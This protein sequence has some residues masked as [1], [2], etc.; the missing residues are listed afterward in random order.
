MHQALYHPQYGYYS[1]GHAKLGR[2]GDYYTNVSVGPMFGRL[3]AFQFTEIWEQL[4]R[5]PK[6]EIVEQGAHDG[7]FAHDVLRE[8]A[9][10][11]PECSETI[12]YHIIE[13]FPPLRE[14]QENR[15]S[16]FGDRLEWSLAL[17]EVEPFVGV[18]FSNELLD[19]MPVH[20]VRRS[21]KDGDSQWT[22]KL[23]NWQDERFGF[24]EAPFSDQRIGQQLGVLADVPDEVEVEINLVAFDWITGLS[25]KLRDGHVIAIDYGYVTADLLALRQRAGTLQCRAQHRL[26]DSPFEVIGH[27]DITAHVNWSAIASHAENH[28]FIL[29][30]FTDQHHFLTGIVAEHP[31]AIQAAD[32]SARRQLQTLLHPEMMGRSFQVLGLRR[33][34]TGTPDLS[35]FKFARPAREQL[36]LD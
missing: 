20:L 33:D 1:S 12:R 32:A 29:G 9:T 16:E 7:Q 28:G 13:P 24:V 6:F 21:G 25:E 5:P 15:L 23:V 8:L 2:R 10:I 36:G 31:A 18:H 34:T 30:G 11:S 14:A 27:C 35:G 22:E 26:V 17:D 4:G 3:L 19:S